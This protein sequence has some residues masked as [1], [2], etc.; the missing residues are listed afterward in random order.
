MRQPGISI[1]PGNSNLP[2]SAAA[3]PGGQNVN[4]VNSKAV[5]RWPVATSPSLSAPVRARFLARYASRVTTEGELVISSQRY[6][7]SAQNRDDCWK[8]FA[9]CSPPWPSP[10]RRRKTKP[11]RGAVE[12]R[13]TQKRQTSGRKQQARERPGGDGD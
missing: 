1:P 9:K 6:R 2:S 12:R 3:G 13:L 4:K 10:I 8:N 5:L 11:S 7:G